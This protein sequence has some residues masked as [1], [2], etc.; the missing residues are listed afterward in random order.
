MSWEPRRSV[1]QPS[2]VTHH[3]MTTL[4]GYNMYVA[5]APLVVVVVVGAP[6]GNTTSYIHIS[7]IVIITIIIVVVLLCTEAAMCIRIRRANNI[8][9]M[10]A[11]TYLYLGCKWDYDAL[12][13]DRFISNN[14]RWRV[15]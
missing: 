6:G 10:T 7:V 9:R 14:D 2:P 3:R 5:L 12:T 1:A 4:S 8:T 11:A 13:M 15:T